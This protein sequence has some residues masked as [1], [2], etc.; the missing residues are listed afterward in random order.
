M[1]GIDIGEY[2]KD[3]FF[4]APTFA[5]YTPKTFEQAYD[6]S[7]FNEI[8]SK[9]CSAETKPVGIPRFYGQPR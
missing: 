1:A 4:S 5:V 3:H 9:Y 6:A 8:A 7:T 2:R